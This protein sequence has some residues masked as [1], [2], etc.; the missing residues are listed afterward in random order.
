MKGYGKLMW[1]GPLFYLALAG[2]TLLGIVALAHAG[3]SRSLNPTGDK[4]I[5]EWFQQLR[6]PDQPRVSCCGEA[7]AFEADEWRDDKGA[8][9][10]IITDGRGVIPNGTAVRVPDAKLAPPTLALNQDARNLTGHGIIFLHIITPAEAHRDALDSE[11]PYDEN[12][13]GRILV[14]CY[15]RPYGA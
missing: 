1:V 9:M 10:A 6:Q 11:S 12:D 3:D 8:Y 7:D 2:L 4:A 13:A 14:F 15:V 5:A